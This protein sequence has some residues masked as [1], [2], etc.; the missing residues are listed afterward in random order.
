MPSADSPRHDFAD[1]CDKFTGAPK[2]RSPF[3]SVLSVVQLPGC[4]KE[5]FDCLAAFE[6]LVLGGR[7]VLIAQMTKCFTTKLILAP[8][9]AP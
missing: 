5:Q 4:A 2:L 9:K 6:M 7:L 3:Q 8:K 1:S